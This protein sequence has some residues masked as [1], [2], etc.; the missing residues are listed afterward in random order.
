MNFK[1]RFFCVFF[2]LCLLSFLIFSQPA[3]APD[4][5][6]KILFLTKELPQSHYGG[7]IIPYKNIITLSERGHDVHLIS[8]L[9]PED[10][11]FVNEIKDHCTIRNLI[12]P[13][14][15][16]D[17]APSYIPPYYLLRYSSEMLKAARTALQRE[18]FDIVICDYS[19]MG[20]YLYELYLQNQLPEN[21]RTILRVHESYY[22]ARLNAL[23]LEKTQQ[24]KA[25]T[26]ELAEAKR[27][28]QG[29]KI[30]ESKMYTIFD[31]V[32]A[33]THEDA[34]RIQEL[35]AT[36]EVKIV[37]HGVGVKEFIYNASKPTNKNLVFVGNYGHKPNVEAVMY[38][39]QDVWPMLLRWIPDVKF[40][41]VGKDPTPTMIELAQLDP[42][43]ILRAN[44]PD[45]K[46]YLEDAQ[47]FI[48]PIQAGSGLRGKVLEAM[49]IGT[50][51]VSTE[52]GAE[53]ISGRRNGEN[54]VIVKDNDFIGFAQ[55]INRLLVN[56]VMHLGLRKKGRQLVE[57]SFDWPHIGKRLETVF[58]ETLLKQSSVTKTFVT[59]NREFSCKEVF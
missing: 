14:T 38:F 17:K 36:I 50:P 28:F 53:G 55:A 24:G 54:I 43:I 3:K 5:S 16:T 52:R 45:V 49:A 9:N 25:N 34:I 46:P 51:V 31:Q 18:H 10:S 58:F 20:Q 6:L 15:L 1:K 44:V 2:K 4:G 56:E 59:R 47:V 7:L 11:P 12:P 35:A 42:N 22:H 8:F 39:Y 19:A 41:I 48:N 33:L 37:P 13:P 30:Y 40:Y 29:L 57:A 23:E 21:T 26:T 27:N 32:V